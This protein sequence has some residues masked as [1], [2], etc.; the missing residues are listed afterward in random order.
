MARSS[1][2]PRGPS[3]PSVRLLRVGPAACRAAPRPR[4]REPR[5]V[6]RFRARVRRAFVSR[7]SAEGGRARR[8]HRSESWRV[9]QRREKGFAIRGLDAGKRAHL[10]AFAG[11]RDQG[12]LRGIELDRLA[13]EQAEDVVGE[14]RGFRRQVERRGERE[15][16]RERRQKLRE[17][18]IVGPE[19]DLVRLERGAVSRRRESPLFKEWHAARL[20]HR[21]CEGNL[22]PQ[23]HSRACH[24]PRNRR[25]GDL[26]SFLQIK[27][28]TSGL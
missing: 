14:R 1:F 11:D 12:R 25:P 13:R 10:R 24:R 15:S 26:S 22:C 3:W 20:Y 6:G 2:G 7:R 5:V 17:P 27:E 16:I 4:R 8:C 23:P 28:T 21:R 9:P 19:L 18:G